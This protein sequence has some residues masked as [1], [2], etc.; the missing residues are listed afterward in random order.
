LGLITVVSSADELS[1]VLAH[2]LSHVTQRHVVHMIARQTQQTPWLIGGMILAVLAASKS[3]D[4]GSALMAGS[5]AAMVQSQLNFSRDMERQADRMGFGVMTQAGFAA[6][7]FVTMFE[8]LQQAAGLNDNG[9][10][11]YLRSHPLTT[12]RM[13]DMQ[14]RVGLA[15]A[16]A[17]PPTTPEHAMLVARAIVLT[18]VAEATLL[19]SHL[20]QASAPDTATRSG[21]QQAGL[22]YAAALAAMQLR[23]GAAA[24][25][26]L[27][28]L[29][30]LPELADQAAAPARLAAYLAVELALAQ[31]DVA[32][33]QRHLQALQNSLGVSPAASLAANR[34]APSDLPRPAL[35]LWAEVAWRAGAAAELRLVSSALSRWVLLHPRDALAWQWLARANTALGL[36]LQSLRAQAEVQAA[37]LDDPGA[38]DRLLAAQAL[39]RQMGAKLSPADAVEAAIVDVRR[40][41]IE[42]RLQENALQ[43]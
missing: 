15:A 39:L 9:S 32:D 25:W 41:Q 11:P 3:P 24:Q 43:R 18:Q 40:R 13:A 7:G 27:A 21:A 8:K 37:Y 2:E 33:A 42:S 1:A 20:L 36:P 28:R 22:F 16:P 38:L 30:A 5:Q 12:E 26:W 31:G 4:A 14:G 29:R 17:L 23:D 35:M 34:T 10:Y 19:R 6:A